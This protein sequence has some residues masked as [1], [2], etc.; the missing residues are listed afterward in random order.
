M[1]QEKEMDNPW[2][3]QIRSFKKIIRGNPRKLWVQSIVS[4]E[5]STKSKLEEF[6]NTKKWTRKSDPYQVTFQVT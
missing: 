5:A 2:Q 3:D 6:S 4:N 1:V